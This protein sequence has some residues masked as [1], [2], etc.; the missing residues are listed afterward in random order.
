MSMILRCCFSFIFAERR[1][2]ARF[3]NNK[4]VGVSL[5]LAGAEIISEIKKKQKKFLI[6]DNKQTIRIMD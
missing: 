5:L 4:Q 1:K 6:P 3:G 2:R